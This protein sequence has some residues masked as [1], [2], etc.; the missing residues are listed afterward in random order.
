MTVLTDQTSSEN[1]GQEGSDETS[2]L[3]ALRALTYHLR[4]MYKSMF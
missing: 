1:H 2:A 3:R 4:G